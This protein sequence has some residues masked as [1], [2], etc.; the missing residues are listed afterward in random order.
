MF[1]GR[2]F[3][4]YC[5]PLAI[6]HV[7]TPTYNPRS[8]GQTERFVDTFKRALLK[9]QEFDTDE[10]SIRIFLTIYRIIP[11]NNTVGKSSQAE[12]VFARKIRSVFDRFLPKKKACSKRT[13]SKCKVSKEAI[14][15]IG[16]GNPL[17][18]WL[19]H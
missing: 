2:E 15:T 19:N 1:T 16:M 12:M 7:T 13:N 8:K 3:R 11:N 18:R 6:E 10:K 4:E 14:E 9:N 5:K 17:G